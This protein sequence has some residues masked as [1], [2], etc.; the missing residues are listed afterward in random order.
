MITCGHLVK[1]T[2]VRT[3]LSVPRFWFLSTNKR[4]LKL[5]MVKILPGPGSIKFLREAGEYPGCEEEY[6]V[7]KWKGEAKSSSL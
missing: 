1:Y 2:R 7:E 5:N 6:N 3:L 4:G